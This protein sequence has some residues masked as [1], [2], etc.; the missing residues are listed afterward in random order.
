MANEQEE[1]ERAAQEMHET[2]SDSAKL[3]AENIK[4]FL[5]LQAQSR[6]ALIMRAHQESLEHA[7]KTAGLASEL[8]AAN[9]QRF[10]A[11]QA[12]SR[13]ALIMRAHST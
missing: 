2:T 7:A 9:I 5:E 6:E 8:L 1:V 4:R 13:E 10:L 11:L 3:A 12:Q